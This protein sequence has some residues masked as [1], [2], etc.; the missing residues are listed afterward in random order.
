MRVLVTGATGYVGH[1]FAKY[2]VTQGSRLGVDTVRVS[3]RQ[4]AAAADLVAQGAE[5]MAGDLNDA[6]SCQALV[7]GMDVVVHCAG[8]NG[9]SGPARNYVVNVQGTANVLTAARAA[10]VRRLV[11][12][13]TASIYFDFSDRSDVREDDVPARLPDHYARSKYAA[14]SALLAAHGDGIE[15][16]SLRPCFVS[17]YGDRRILPRWIALHQSGNLMRI[18]DGRNMLD[19]TAI[20]NMV[21]ALW[22]AMTAPA[23]SCGRAYNISNGDPVNIW[24]FID[25]LMDDLGM[26]LVTAHIPYRLA[27]G[28]GAVVEMATRVLRREPPLSRLGVAIMAKTF[29]L[30]ID[31]A[32]E[33]LGYRPRMTN[34]QMR[35]DFCAWWRALEHAAA[36]G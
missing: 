36:R 4:A 30:N 12:V 29:I 11:N 21:D 20:D 28:I 13:G 7:A 6:S 15:T 8:V 27:Y 3:G 35:A 14:E 31:A 5:W 16:I 34:S 26:E 23:A 25:G 19:F 17:G 22:L 9:L 1:A 18:G 32:R 2:L 10:G 24:N 33:Q